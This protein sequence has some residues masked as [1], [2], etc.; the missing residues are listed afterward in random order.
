MNPQYITIHNTANDASADNEHTYMTKTNAGS[1]TGSNPIFNVEAYQS[2]KLVLEE[3]NAK[4]E[5]LEAR[6]ALLE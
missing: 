4:Y 5:S 6:V 1:S 3:S 2:T